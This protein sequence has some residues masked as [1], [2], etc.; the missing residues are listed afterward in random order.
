MK[1]KTTNELENFQ[2]SDTYIA[3]IRTMSESF[4]M[5]LDNVTILPENSCNRD[6]R[7]MR[8]NGLELRILKA[9]VD[10]VVEEGYK[11]YD[12]DG[13]LMR[14]E[15]DREVPVEEYKET[16]EELAGCMLYSVERCDNVYTFSI[17]TEDH[18][19]LIKVSG[20]DDMEEWDRFLLYQG[21]TD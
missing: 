12:A 20:D 4:L 18:T 16:F 11:V 2:F 7:K 13:K 10:S 21:N 8:I 15:E 6:I 19:F 1:Y 5:M 9:K 3:E 17:D 14:R